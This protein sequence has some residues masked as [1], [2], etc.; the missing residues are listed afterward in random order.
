M[1]NLAKMEKLNLKRDDVVAQPE[2]MMANQNQIIKNKIKKKKD[3]AC[4]I[5]QDKLFQSRA[6]E[7]NKEVE[8]KTKTFKKLEEQKLELSKQITELE[9]RKDANT[10]EYE[11]RRERAEEEK[12]IMVQDM[13]KAKNTFKKSQVAIEKAKITS[14]KSKDNLAN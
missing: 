2:L 11:D 6:D 5:F 9:T 4:K 10:I 12:K 7:A 13:E 1:H 8:I 14:Q 3:E